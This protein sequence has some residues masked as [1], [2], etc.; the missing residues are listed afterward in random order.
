MKQKINEIYPKWMPNTE[1]GKVLLMKIP[2]HCWN[3]G[4]VGLITSR[5]DDLKQMLW[6]C[7]E[8]W[9]TLYMWWPSNYFIAEL[10]LHPEILAIMWK[11]DGT[12][13]FQVKWKYMKWSW[14]VVFTAKGSYLPGLNEMGKKSTPSPQNNFRHWQGHRGGTVVVGGRG[15]GGRHAPGCCQPAKSLDFHTGLETSEALVWTIPYHTVPLWSAD[16]A[17][18][19]GW[20]WGQTLTSGMYL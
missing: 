14:D 4:V 17:S 3:I 5:V 18:T 1:N 9:K 13:A 12:V 7:Q 19:I 20:E 2:D 11:S 15:Q 6:L 8:N 10:I 16:R